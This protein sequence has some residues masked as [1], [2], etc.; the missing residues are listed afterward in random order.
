MSNMKIREFSG[1][2]VDLNDYTERF[3]STDSPQKPELTKYHN[4][5][6]QEFAFEYIGDIDPKD[7]TTWPAGF[8]DNYNIRLD[9]NLIETTDAL[10]YDMRVNGWSTESFPPITTTCGEWKDG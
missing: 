1:K 8:E 5:V 9:A 2:P 10:S 7:R 6:F 4:L 3:K